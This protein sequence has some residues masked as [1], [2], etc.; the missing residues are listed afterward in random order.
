MSIGAALRRMGHATGKLD[1]TR[2]Y[3]T[4]F[5]SIAVSVLP[6]G[7][8]YAYAGYT[9][10]LWP[11]FK[12]L[13][14]RFP[15]HRL[16]S[17]AVFASDDGD[18]LDIENGD[19]TIEEAPG[20]Y[21]RQVHRGVWRPAL[22]TSASNL[23][24]LQRIMA[25]A[26]IAR[27]DYRL[28]SAHYLNKAHLCAPKSCG[29]GLSEADG[30][31]WTSRALGISLDQSI[32]LPD[33]FDPRPAP[34]PPSPKPVPAPPKPTPTPKPVTDWQ[35]T[36]LS[37]LPTLKQGDKDGPGKV[38]FVGRMQSL[39]KYIG[40]VNSLEAAKDLTVDGDFGIHT[41]NAL[42]SI[43]SFFG[44]KCD[45]LCGPATWRVLVTGEK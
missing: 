34:K 4:M 25:A 23:K 41:T 43:Q 14:H 21:E 44:L 2:P 42:L 33:F 31:Q 1:A 13:Q 35:E 37:A 29:Y 3:I 27:A 18:C 9:G 11:T 16:L 40:K 17:I 7:G 5:D 39:I 45:R 8:S 20:W 38:E 6:S 19:A 12:T 24:A 10:G 22:Y 28:W 32:L 15:G 30:C 36:M 26:H